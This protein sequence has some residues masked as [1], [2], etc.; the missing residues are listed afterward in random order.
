VASCDPFDNVEQEPAT[1]Y[2]LA[3]SIFTRMFGGGQ[4][5]AAILPYT[6]DSPEGLAARW[7]RWVA[8]VGPL[9]NPVGDTTGADAGVN[10][11][12]DVWFLAGTFGGDVERRCAVP[13]GTSLFLP[14]FNMWHH[15]ADGPPPDLPRAFGELV[16]DGS[17][18]ELDTITTPVPFEVVGV[19]L[20][21]VTRTS[22]PMLMT[23]WGIWKRLD[24]LPAGQHVLR[25]AGG[26]GHG[27]TVCAT[28][29]LSVT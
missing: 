26:D 5:P 13:A 29:H 23:V 3:V 1:R 25:F 14:A 8:G 22:K 16:V 20:N 6:T 4:R 2:S 7:V 19:R 12:D 9:H 24:P 21:P 11:P 10:Q 18:I 27:F 28:Y 17:S 15:H